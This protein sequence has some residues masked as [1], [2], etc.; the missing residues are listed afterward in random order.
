MD[1][2]DEVVQVLYTTIEEL[3]TA[4]GRSVP[5]GPPDDDVIGHYGLT[6]VDVLELLLTAEE[7][8]D[9]LFEDDEMDKTMVGSARGLARRI[10]AE[11]AGDAGAG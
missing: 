6:S 11:Q 1:D 5:D 2:V 9:V 3:L 10:L 7:R 8:F 4:S